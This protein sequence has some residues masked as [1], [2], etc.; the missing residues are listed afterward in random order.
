VVLIWSGFMELDETK[1]QSAKP[2]AKLEKPFDADTLRKLVK[3]LLGNKVEKTSTPKTT[4]PTSKSKGSSERSDTSDITSVVSGA[5]S[6][7]QS[8]FSGQQDDLG[9][10]PEPSA[11][12]PEDQWAML[13]LSTVQNDQS[14][15]SNEEK[16]DITKF[17]IDLPSDHED[18]NVT[19]SYDLLAEDLENLDPNL[20][21]DHSQNKMPEQK[22]QIMEP[23]ASMPPAATS[24][25]ASPPTATSPTAIQPIKSPEA[26]QLLDKVMLDADQKNEVVQMVVRTLIL[27]LT[28]DKIEELIKAQAEITIKTIAER[29]IPD[30]AEKMIKTELERLL[31]D[32]ETGPGI[33]P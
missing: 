1:L 10:L 2:D 13:R 14:K 31:K 29:L 9:S 15:G 16:S 21:N 33:L 20:T 22:P 25:T 27:S 18:S 4:Q 30:V 17:K 32:N 23:L 24:P 5:F 8:P 19:V 6:K 28:S 12:N 26:A 11:P 7:A 3:D